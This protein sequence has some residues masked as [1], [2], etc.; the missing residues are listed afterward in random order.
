MCRI[1]LP[2]CHNRDA[3]VTVMWHRPY[4]S[5]SYANL[6]ANGLHAHLLLKLVWAMA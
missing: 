2:P 5:V 6:S 3:G 4:T 1:V